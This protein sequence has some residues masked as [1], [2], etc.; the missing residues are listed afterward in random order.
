MVELSIITRLL[1]H[2]TTVQWIQQVVPQANQN[3]FHTGG[4]K[5]RIFKNEVACF[6]QHN[7]G[8]RFLKR[9]L[10]KLQLD[11]SLSCFTPVKNNK[12]FSPAL[13]HRALK[14]MLGETQ[15]ASFLIVYSN[16][17]FSKIKVFSFI[18]VSA[19]QSQMK[20]TQSILLVAHWRQ[21]SCVFHTESRVCGP[22]Y[23]CLKRQKLM[24][25]AITTSFFF[26]LSF[27]AQNLIKKSVFSALQYNQKAHSN[28]SIQRGESTQLLA[29]N[30]YNVIA[31]VAR[32]FGDRHFLNVGFPVIFCLTR[33][34]DFVSKNTTSTFENRKPVWIS[35]RYRFEWFATLIFIGYDIVC[36]IHCTPVLDL[37]PGY[38]L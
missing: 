5:S 10:I 36:R 8:L 28:K 7:S 24:A 33:F 21:S 14:S 32:A 29:G 35:L 16:G 3:Q 17:Y 34:G 25:T 26:N 18:R 37:D 2:T 13:R 6:H 11:D 19:F 30:S 23:P 4:N 27:A 22:V 1:N 38:I 9:R 31:Q 12:R 15:Q 20:D